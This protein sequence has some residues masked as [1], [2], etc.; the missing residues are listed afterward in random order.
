MFPV[1]LKP[2]QSH[3]SSLL[4]YFYQNPFLRSVNIFYCSLQFGKSLKE[5]LDW[6]TNTNTAT[7]IQVFSALDKLAYTVYQ[8]RCLKEVFRFFIALIAGAATT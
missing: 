1:L 6:Y 2:F 8:Q 5:K 3:D 4:D 7:K